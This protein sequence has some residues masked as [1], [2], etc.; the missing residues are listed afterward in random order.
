MQQAAH[1]WGLQQG[2]RKWGSCYGQEAGRGSEVP[3]QG[4]ASEIWKKK[5]KKKI[6]IP[7]PLSRPWGEAQDCVFFKSVSAAQQMILNHRHEPDSDAGIL[8]L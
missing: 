4:W 7:G 1:L 3:N 6:Q 8:R 2:L 5:K